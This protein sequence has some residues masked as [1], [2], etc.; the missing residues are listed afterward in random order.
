MRATTAPAAESV[1][2]PYRLPSQGPCRPGIEL[3][4]GRESNNAT[5]TSAYLE[6]KSNSTLKYGA[7]AIPTQQY[8]YKQVVEAESPESLVFDRSRST[9]FRY[10]EVGVVSKSCE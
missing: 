8:S 4:A 5:P 10:D 1:R 3:L 6:K 2:A 9:F 7:M